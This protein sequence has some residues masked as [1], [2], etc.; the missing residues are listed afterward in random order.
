VLAHLLGEELEERLDELRLAVE[1]LAQLR[2]LRGDA[3][4]A[5]VEVADAHHDA[6]E[7]TSGAVAKPYSSGAEQRAM[8]TSRPVL[9]WPSTCTTIRSR[10]PLSSSVCC[11]SARPELPRRAGVL[12]RGQGRGAGAAVVAGDEHDV[13]VRLGH[14]GR[15]RA[16]ADLGDELDVDPRAVVGVLEVVDELARSSI[17]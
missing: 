11:V 17:E 13:G 2:V 8:T 5:G 1:P 7:T 9:S 10:R 16:D 12:E 6:A 3:D 14:A 4:R 15:D